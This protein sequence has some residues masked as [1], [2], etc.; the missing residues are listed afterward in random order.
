MCSASTIYTSIK[1]SGLR[2]GDFAVFPGAGGGVGM[3]GVQLAKAMG[4]RA[5]AIDTG[6]DKRKL[7]LETAGAEEF[8]DF[9]SSAY[10]TGSARMASS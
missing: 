5:I 2:P 8:I 10:V 4:L 3:Q 6:D 1:D 9:K 7:C